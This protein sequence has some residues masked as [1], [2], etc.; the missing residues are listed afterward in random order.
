MY[1]ICCAE[2]HTR[3]EP[4][5]FGGWNY[6]LFGKQA[7]LSRLILDQAHVTKETE[8]GEP[9]CLEDED[10]KGTTFTAHRSIGLDP[11]TWIR[12]Y[13]DMRAIFLTQLWHTSTSLLQVSPDDVFIYVQDARS[14][15]GVSPQ[16]CYGSGLILGITFDLQHDDEEVSVYIYPK[17][18]P[19]VMQIDRAPTQVFSSHPLRLLQ[20]SLKEVLL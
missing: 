6:V 19:I 3:E 9:C 5:S 16:Y 12:A 15:S 20:E 8:A 17:N 13:W 2:L 14:Q 11:T 18:Y 10:D 4:E 7:H 1:G